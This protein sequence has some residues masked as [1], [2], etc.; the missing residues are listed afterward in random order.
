MSTDSLSAFV[1]AN[2][3]RVLSNSDFNLFVSCFS[4]FKSVTFEP[5]WPCTSREGE[6]GGGGG[7]EGGRVRG[8]YYNFSTQHTNTLTAN[9]VTTYR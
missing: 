4:S 8:Q 6:G 7:E 5:S 1:S 3:S 9:I 2:S